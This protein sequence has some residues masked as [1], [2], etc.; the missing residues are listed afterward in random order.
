MSHAKSILYAPLYPLLFAVAPV[1]SLYAVNRMLLSGFDALRPAAVAILVAFAAVAV[2]RM[3]SNSMRSAAILGCVLLFGVF[4]YG[5]VFRFVSLAFGVEIG[6]I[7]F[8][9][10]WLLL[11]AGVYAFLVRT[12]RRTRS[13]LHN[14]TALLNI[15]SAVFVVTAAAPLLLGSAPSLPALPTPKAETDA[16]GLTTNELPPQ[17]PDLV[18]QPNK[19]PDVYYLILDGYARGDVLESRFGYDN[20]EFLDWL[21]ARGFFV[22]HRSHSNYPWTHLSMSATLNYEYLQTLLPDGLESHGPDKFRERY[23]FLARALNMHYI[24]NSR[25]FRYFSNLGY[26]ITANK[27]HY[28]LEWRKDPTSLSDALSEIMD[29][30]EDAYSSSISDFEEA[31]IT[32]TIVQP[33]VSGFRSVEGV[34]AARISKYDKIVRGLEAFGDTVNEDG[35]KFVFYHLTSPHQPF[36]FD[37]NGDMVP[38]HPVY[39]VS[40]W[41]EDRIKIPGYI[42]WAKENY[43]KNVAGL[44]VHVK[45]TIERI[46]D[47]SEGSAIV[48]IQSDHGPGYGFDLHSGSDTD[49]VERFGILNAIFLPVEFPRHGLED[50]LSAVNTF[51]IVLRN[52]FGQDMSTLENRAF[53]SIGDLDFEDVTKRVVDSE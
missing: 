6:D 46:L 33:L 14:I 3:L 40:A 4:A 28:A 17:S 47:E 21:E 20:S 50:D 52:V 5:Y 31:L 25:I 23:Q 41:F 11:L 32:N 26:R 15:T 37:E 43:P 39:E 38:R 10:T 29:E 42:A 22:G 30:I 24:A 13:S 49:V 1:V 16:Q 36:S 51:R 34:R 44:N 18:Q 8:L 7:V 53:Y 48:I 9:S 19:L 35:P 27:S 12:L 2:S 45:R